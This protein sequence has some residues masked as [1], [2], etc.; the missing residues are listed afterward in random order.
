MRKVK[1]LCPL[2]LLTAFFLAVFALTE[3]GV[4]DDSDQYIKMHIHR[5]PLYP[6]FLAA[7]RRLFGD[8][9][10]TAMGIIQGVLAAVS[11]R[12]FAEWTA[13]HFSLHAW[14]KCAVYLLGLAPYAA[15]GFFSSLHIFIPG[16]VM[17]EA[18]C[19]P[20]FTFFMTECWELA[21]R[22]EGR[23]FQRAAC[24]SLFLAFLLSLTRSQMLWTFALWAGLVIWNVRRRMRKAPR[25]GNIALADR[26]RTGADT[27]SPWKLA[28]CETLAG[29][30][31]SAET[32]RN[33]RLTLRL[34]LRSA[35]V[36]GI[37][38]LV[39][40]GR[41]YAV[42]AYNLVFNGRF[43]NNTYG[44][45]NTLAN[46]LYASDRE[47]GERISDP[48]ARAFFYEMYDLADQNRANYKYAGESIR[49]Q[50]EYFEQW[51]DTIKYEMVENVFYETYNETVTTDY[52][53]QNLLADETAGRII[54]GVFPA[55]LGQWLWD[56]LLLAGYG[57][58]RSIAVVQGAVNVAAALLYVSAAVLVI[59]LS[60]RAGGGKCGAAAFS[61]AEAGKRDAAAFSSAKAERTS[62]ATAAACLAVA[63]AAILMN[64]A[65]VSVTIICLS[66]YMV[67]GFAPFYTAYCL[68]LREVG[69]RPR[70]RPGNAAEAVR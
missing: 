69:K 25:A 15:T 54:A 42:K 51:H 38:A 57:L 10:M 68:A 18:L 6:L 32:G 23:S 34:F 14:E 66:R 30:A 31:G 9:W 59:R 5:E 37:V 70:L 2:L 12:R 62:T 3:P 50:A 64:T 45:V 13:A 56:Y 16:S 65:T 29:S 17:S 47:D 44:T 67:Y 55:C 22:G 19:L 1:N 49:E 52:I 24:L 26:G 27:E 60:R 39:L 48:E 43:I 28:H 40:A 8:G 36:I 11:I 33:L 46:I 4:Y 20:L 63:V 58:I 35:A 7:L 21:I 61:S 41:L 53:E